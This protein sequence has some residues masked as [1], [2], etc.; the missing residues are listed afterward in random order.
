MPTPT[1]TDASLEAVRSRLEQLW[2]AAV[3]VEGPPPEAG[4]AQALAFGVN[5]RVNLASAFAAAWE[6]AQAVV[7]GTAAAHAPFDIATWFEAGA[8]AIGAIRTI[9]ASLVQRMRP[10]DY[11]TSVILANHPEGMTSKALRGAVEEFLRD[12]KARRLCMVS[13]HER[14]S[15]AARA[16]SPRS[17]RLVRAIAGE[18]A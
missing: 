17:T 9:F 5:L 2:A 10:I 1:Q 12:P 8:E 11:V 4:T 13:R 15:G 18:T 3:V 16:G 14:G 7:K 6:T